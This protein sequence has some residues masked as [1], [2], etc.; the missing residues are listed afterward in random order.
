VLPTPIGNGTE[1]DDVVDAELVELELLL[2]AGVLE[3]LVAGPVVFEPAE[4]LPGD[5]PPQ[6]ARTRPAAATSAAAAPA[7]LRAEEADMFMFLTS[8]AG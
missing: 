6:A 4:V 1:S 3:L 8:F 7:R 5:D 2:D